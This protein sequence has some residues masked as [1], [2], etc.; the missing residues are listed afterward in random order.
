MWLQV[1]IFNENNNSNFLNR[2]AYVDYEVTKN[3]TIY[4]IIIEC[5]KLA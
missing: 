5:S 1:T 4:L 2:R 3:E